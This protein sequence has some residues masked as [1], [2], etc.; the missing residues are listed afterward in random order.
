MNLY[1]AQYVRFKLKPQHKY[2]QSRSF[3]SF[4]SARDKIDGKSIKR[5]VN[6]AYDN[7]FINKEHSRS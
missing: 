6:P 1:S 3:I 7:I 4:L 5:I 2:F